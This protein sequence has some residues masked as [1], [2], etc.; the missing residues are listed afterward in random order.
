MKLKNA[1]RMNCCLSTVTMVTQTRQN[2]TCYFVPHR[3]EL[4]YRIN[5]QNCTDP[6]QETALTHILR[7][8]VS[9]NVQYPAAYSYN[10]DLI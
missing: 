6:L 7:L 4:A 9:N 2:V 3:V 5:G 8:Q 10:Y 1:H